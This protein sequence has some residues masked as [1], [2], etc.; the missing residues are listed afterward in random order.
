MIRE[1][2]IR[3][4]PLARH[5]FSHTTDPGRAAVEGTRAMSPHRLHIRPAELFSSDQHAVGIGDSPWSTSPT[6]GRRNSTPFAP[7]DYHTLQVAPRCR[8]TVS[9]SHEGSR[10]GAAVTL[11]G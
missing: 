7:M 5:I 11:P 3:H 2:A 1:S 4:A 9:P 8:R 10:P 6:A